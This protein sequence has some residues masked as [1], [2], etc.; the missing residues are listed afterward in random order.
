MRRVLSVFLLLAI[1]RYAAYS[2]RL[3]LWEWIG[4]QGVLFLILPFLAIWW[5]EIDGVEFGLSFGEAKY[6][7]RIALLLV[8]LALPIMAYGASLPSFKAYYPI[9]APARTS[10]YRLV[11][12]ELGV[13]IMMLST[14]VYFRGL[15]L[16]SL[17]KTLGNYGTSRTWA[18]LLNAFIYMLA[19]IGKPGLEVPYSFF[20]G[21]IFAWLA[22]RTRSIVPSLV[23]HWV[24]SVIFDVLVLII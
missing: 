19:H 5:Y 2:M 14:E 16:F 23:A 20:V 18:I 7:V 15:L 9:W 17:E 8:L 10:V 4:V 3:S 13:F 12:L 22:L 1:E 11:L 24:S 21:V 6:G